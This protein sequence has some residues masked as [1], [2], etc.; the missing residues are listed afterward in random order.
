M[1][2][3]VYIVVRP[4]LEYQLPECARA[5]ADALVGDD[6]DATRTLERLN[7]R[8]RAATTEQSEVE[9]TRA[10]LTDDGTLSELQE[11]CTRVLGETDEYVRALESEWIQFL[12]RMATGIRHELQSLDRDR[13]QIHA[14]YMRYRNGNRVVAEREYSRERTHLQKRL[15][16]ILRRYRELAQPT[17][18][19][20]TSLQGATQSL[21]E[22]FAA[23]HRRRVCTA[24]LQAVKH[25]FE[26]QLEDM[27]RN[28]TRSFVRRVTPLLLPPRAS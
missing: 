26:R 5:V 17:C 27:Q 1:D 24:D 10:T 22:A 18:E 8:A 23:A 11:H 9:V 20:P 13:A 14:I 16:D 25:R 21:R 3:R 4:Y 12:Q 2:P 15:D 6:S 7:V 28:V 19:R